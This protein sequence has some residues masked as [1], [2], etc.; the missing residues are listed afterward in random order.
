MARAKAAKAQESKPVV[1]TISHRPRP[2]ELSRKQHERMQKRRGI[3]ETEGQSQGKSSD[4]GARNSRREVGASGK[5]KKKKQTLPSYSGTAK[6]K[7]LREQPTY[8]GTA[9]AK[10][11]T[12]AAVKSK[13]RQNEYAGTDED[14]DSYGEEEE[15]D[16]DD[17]GYGYSDEESDDMEAGYMDVEEEE[18]R[19]LKFAQ[20]EDEQ[21]LRK[22]NALKQEKEQRKK[23]LEELK[24]RRGPQKY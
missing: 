12:K 20:K 6:P 22:E 11:V 7:P 5:Q 2:Q 19:A 17:N 10:P 4:K 8:K 14:I 13:H 24:S 15:E 21:E 18:S 1:G 9:G 23:K 3:F 16:D